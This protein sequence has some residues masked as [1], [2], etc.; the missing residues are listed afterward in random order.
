[1]SC[2]K[3]RQARLPTEA[4]LQALQTW[5]MDARSMMDTFE[6]TEDEAAEDTGTA[7]SQADI[8]VFDEGEGKK[9]MFVLW[10]LPDRYSIYTWE[11]G[12]LKAMPDNSEWVERFLP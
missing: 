6:F 8:A 12:K 11:G 7:I 4:E 2:D 10:E 1:M 9:V 5:A 3:R